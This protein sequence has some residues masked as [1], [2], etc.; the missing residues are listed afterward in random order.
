MSQP[1]LPSRTDRAVSS[2]LF[3][4]RLNQP[5]TMEKGWTLDRLFAQSPGSP[6]TIPHQRASRLGVVPPE[7]IDTNVVNT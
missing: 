6:A 4:E 2:G 7:W 3:T 5:G 1:T